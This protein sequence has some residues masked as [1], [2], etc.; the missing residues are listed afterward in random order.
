MATYLMMMKLTTPG[1]E[2]IKNAHEG[3]VAG[4]KMAKSLGIKWK[5]QYLVFGQYD[6]ITVVEADSDEQMATF[7]L[8]GGLSGTF[9]IETLRAFTEAEAD[10]LLKSLND[11]APPEMGD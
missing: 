3:R 8:L 9:T 10:K 5:Q 6:L 7:A 2:S 4:K 1:H 11:V